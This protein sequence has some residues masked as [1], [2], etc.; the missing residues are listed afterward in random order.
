MQI[1][2]GKINNKKVALILCIITIIIFIYSSIL[3]KY[4]IITYTS[5]L[6]MIS[7]GILFLNNFKLISAPI[8]FLAFYIY[9]IA[10]GPIILMYQGK[11]FG[12]NYQNIILGTLLCFFIG[13]IIAGFFKLKKHNTNLKKIR[14]KIGISKKNILYILYFISIIFSVIYFYKNRIFLFSGDIENGRISAVSGNGILLYGIQLQ[15]L[16]IAMF[17][18]LYYKNKKNNIDNKRELII[19]WGLIFLS[20][21]IM[22]LTGFRSNVMTLYV[23]LF[24]MY[25][26]KNNIKSYKIIGC[27]IVFVFLI[28]ILSIIRSGENVKML[29]LLL[30]GLYVNDINLNYVF[31][32]FPKKVEFQHGYT[33]L[34]NI[35]MLKPGPDLDFT[36]WL[37]EQI[38]ITFNGGGVTPTI[39]GEFY[40]NFGNLSMYIGMFFLGILGE[41]LNNYFNCNNK[42]FISS[43]YV[44]QFAHCAS[45]GIANVMIIVIL[46]TIVYK[47]ITLFSNTNIAGV[48]VDE[49]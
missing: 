11:D 39:L 44:W 37:K 4:N 42:N 22:L 15:I 25:A 13:N 26:G 35:L 23:I 30:S 24:I 14:F 9:V 45:G 18:D 5:I 29:Q 49:E 21:I 28:A 6:V 8:I 2:S 46:F 48:K 38:G 34:I 1:N 32:T 41:K 17:L 7:I 36:L 43:F 47:S 3:E 27:G 20:T 10:L 12:Y 33:Y 31:S 19:L 40:M 16:I